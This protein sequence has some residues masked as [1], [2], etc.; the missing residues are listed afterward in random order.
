MGKRV[1]ESARV[2]LERKRLGERY[3]AGWVIFF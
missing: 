2:V 3:K 1:R